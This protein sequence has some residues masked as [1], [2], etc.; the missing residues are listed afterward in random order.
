MANWARVNRA[1]FVSV[2]AAGGKR[3]AHQVDVADLGEVTHAPLLA[4]MRYA[5]R[6]QHFELPWLWHYHGTTMALLW[7]S[8]QPSVSVPADGSST[9]LPTGRNWLSLHT[10]AVRA[11]ITGRSSL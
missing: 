2:G 5:L 10:C 7:P 9:S 8:R 3:V 1:L 4:K 6:R 11:S